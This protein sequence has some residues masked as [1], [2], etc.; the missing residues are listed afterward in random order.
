ARESAERRRRR[1][2]RRGGR[3]NRRER[4]DNG[5]LVEADAAHPDVDSAMVELDRQRE[6]P[7]GESQAGQPPEAE[8]PL[9]AAGEPAIP[10]PIDEAV[11]SGAAEPTRT[12][13]ESTRVAVEPARMVVEPAAEPTGA[14]TEPAR[15]AVEPAKMVV[16]P[17]SEPPVAP[18]TN[19]RRSTV[20]E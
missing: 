18:E 15:V 12:A 3:R 11:T 19:R 1:R 5:S 2:G 17:V 9:P 7:F 20:R 6:P 13:A 10:S 14:A 8:Q 16:E 4:E